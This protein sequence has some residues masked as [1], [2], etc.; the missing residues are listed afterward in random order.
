MSKVI[1][2]VGSR[3]R[4]SKNDF[5]LVEQ[6]FLD[7]FTSD[8][9]ICSGKC[10]TGADHFAEI[11]AN[12]YEVDTLFYPAK[13]KRHG[14]AAPFIRNEQIAKASDVLIAC[15]AQDRTGGTEDT[16]EKYKKLGKVKL[17]LV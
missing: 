5:I 14:K 1:G 10:P 12:I 3:R 17:I 9:I 15:I 13:W 6:A 11:L 4:H 7:I 2:I 16:I 8:D